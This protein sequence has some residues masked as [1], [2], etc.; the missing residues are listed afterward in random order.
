MSAGEVPI[1]VAREGDDGLPA[2]A[3]KIGHG[4]LVCHAGGEP[5]RI[6]QG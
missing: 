6:V 4:E 3:R 5:E 1:E 2:T